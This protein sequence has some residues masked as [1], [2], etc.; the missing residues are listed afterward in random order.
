LINTGILHAQNEIPVFTAFSKRNRY[1]ALG[2]KYQYLVRNTSIS[3]APAFFPTCIVGQNTD[4][5]RMQE[6]NTGTTGFLSKTLK[7]KNE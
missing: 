4:A 1:F 5:S 2:A 6:K 7:S 3:L